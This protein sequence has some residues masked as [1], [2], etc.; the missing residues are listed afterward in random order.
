M[1]RSSFVEQRTSKHLAN[2]LVSASPAPPRLFPAH[3]SSPRRPR[4]VEHQLAGLRQL[5]VDERAE[6]RQLVV[7]VDV[8]VQVGRD[9]NVV[10]HRKAGLQG[11]RLRIAVAHGPGEAPQVQQD[12]GGQRPHAHAA[13]RGGGGVRGAHLPPDGSVPS[14]EMHTAGSAVP[15]PAGLLLTRP[16]RRAPNRPS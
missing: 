13:P 12:G 3:L 2:A 6:A 16:R 8:P 7:L 10:P 11:V 14:F 5:R 1:S 15:G 9:R 4:E